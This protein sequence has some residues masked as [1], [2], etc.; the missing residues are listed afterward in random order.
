MHLYIQTLE[1]V[2]IFSI[3]I[4]TVTSCLACSSFC[5]N[6]RLRCISVPNARPFTLKNEFIQFFKN[7]FIS[8]EMRIFFYHRRSMLLRSD[9]R[10]SPMTR[11]NRVETCRKV[12][13]HPRKCLTWQKLLRLINIISSSQEIH[14]A[15]VDTFISLII[16][17][18]CDCLIFSRNIKSEK[19]VFSK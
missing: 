1:G 15:E 3:K 6:T 18:V 14:L 9:G 12:T 19:L 8:F 13:A 7:S 4:V 16:Y 5:N 17:C 10:W 11:Q 2:D